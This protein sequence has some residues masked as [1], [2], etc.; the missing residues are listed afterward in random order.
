VSSIWE[1]AE[2]DIVSAM[3]WSDNEIA[4]A[5][6][7]SKR[8]TALPAVSPSIVSPKLVTTVIAIC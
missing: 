5:T 2:S 4:V 1:H 6:S 8:Q 7:L 3:P